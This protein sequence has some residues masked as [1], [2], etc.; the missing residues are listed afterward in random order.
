MRMKADEL[1]TQRLAETS[2]Y[3]KK[4]AYNYPSKS[5]VTDT[6]KGAPRS[7]VTH[8]ETDPHALNVYAKKSAY[9]YPRKSPVTDTDKGAP[10]SR[11]THP[12]T[13]PYALNVYAK[14]YP[15]KSNIKKESY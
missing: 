12:E 4:G 2:T 9:N 1:I 7:R 11:V 8:P 10:R 5:P 13:D 15:S 3:A 14:N 6:D